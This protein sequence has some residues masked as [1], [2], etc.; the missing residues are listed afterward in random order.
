MENRKFI[1]FIIPILLLGFFVF[2]TPDVWAYGVETHAFLTKTVVDFYNQHFPNKKISEEL[3]N[4]LID[5]ARLED[6][7]PRYM[8]HFYDP[9]NNQGLAN[10]IYQGMA[11][12]DWARDK[13]SQTALLYKIFPQTE[14]PALLTASQIQ[15]I[16]P[17]FNKTDFTW[18]KAV[19]LYA[20]GETEQALFAL[21]HIV[22]LIEDASVPDH[23]R[24]DAHPPYD[25]GGSPYENWT[26]K[27]DLDNPDS[28]LVNNRLRVKKPIL[29]NNLGVYFDSIANY[30]NNNFYSK[31]SI[32]SYDLPVPDYIGK[33][34]IY[35]YGFRKDTEFGDYY[36]IAYKKPPEKYNWIPSKTDDLILTDK[37]QDFVARDYWSRLSTKAVQYSAGVVN[38]FFKEAEAAKQKYLAEKATRP[39]LATLVDGFKNFFSN[40]PPRDIAD[41]VNEFKLVREIPIEKKIL[42][43]SEKKEVYSRVNT[44]KDE[45]KIVETEIIPLTLQSQEVIVVPAEPRNDIP[46]CSFST[47]QTPS[48]QGVILNEVAWMGSANSANDEWIELKNI[49]GSEIDLN[50]WQLVDL[51]EQIKIQLSGALAAGSFYLL[52]RTDDSSAPGLQADQIYTGALSN[53]G[54]G[55]R[56]FNKSCGLVDE[57]MA[58]PDWP[59]GDNGYKKTMER[60][61][62]FS[63]LNYSGVGQDGILGTPKAENSPGAAP[64][65]PGSGGSS[66][67]PTSAVQSS[68]PP[69]SEPAQEPQPPLPPPEPEVAAPAPVKILISEVLF[70]A[71]GS[72]DAKE[73]IELYNPNDQNVDL[74]SWS[75][76]HQSAS[77]SLTKKNFEAGNSIAAKSFFLI[78]LGNDARADL[79]WASGSLNNLSATIYLVNNSNLISTTSPVSMDAVNYNTADLPGFIAG[80]SLERKALENNSCTTPWDSGEYIGNG[81]DTDSQND[82]ELRA[83][84]NP[85]NKQSLPE[86]RLAPSA[87]TNL[88]IAFS[89]STTEL[90]LNWDP[91]AD[92]GGSTNT[93][94]YTLSEIASS[95]VLNSDTLQYKKSVNEIGRD[96]AFEISATDKEGLIGSSTQY[97]YHVSG[98]LDNI[99]FYQDPNATTAP[100]YF[101]D[102]SWDQYPFATKQFPHLASGVLSDNNW[103]AIVFYYN[104][105]AV[106]TDDIFWIDLTGE[107]PYRSWG[108]RVPE[109]LTIL[110][111]NCQGT[112]SGGTS[113]IL[114]DTAGA[115]NSMAGNYSSYA[116][117]WSG[118]G[119]GTHAFAVPS[120]QFEIEPEPENDY[121]TVAYYGFQPGYEPNNYGLRLIAIDKTKY[122][123]K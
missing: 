33:S 37:G 100:A 29:L 85:Q 12:K 68:P 58:A 108:L 63:W 56:L 76:Q 110:Y 120:D 70:D 27:F 60:S 22:H 46:L 75:I 80:K 43:Q 26:S 84:P 66:P 8:N 18:E 104:Q 83:I 41:T 115:C 3:A 45:P 93:L 105:D 123:M 118:I 88:N 2:N 53:V 15:K 92:A 67:A 109:G 44:P 117:D 106:V 111:P 57:V 30:S 107:N 87:V 24:N 59:A 77:G 21:G 98:F 64:F 113:L 62:G 122:Y 49:S 90:I 28:D 4:Y 81:C 102:L 95:T 16:Q 6:N 116:F 23:T 47:S 97:N 19:E 119:I 35:T 103:H 11:S 79:K 52:E 10:G 7:A 74:S 40:D 31:D 17:T 101:L 61:A 82:W 14:A 91:V 25:D 78:W 114:P 112:Q 51:G 94:A 38:L 32:K 39:Y 121:I 9:V 36:L 5:G 72:D 1:K 13:K 71:D 54:E 65:N 96:Y 69:Q 34:G 48:R 86:P 55:L 42:V 20:H 73:F 50:G 99:V 89:S